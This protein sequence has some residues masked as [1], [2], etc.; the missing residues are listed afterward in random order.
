MS[1]HFAFLICF[2]SN[3]SCYSD[4][5]YFQYFS[6]N[7][8]TSGALVLNGPF[9]SHVFRFHLLATAV[10]YLKYDDE[11]HSTCCL[12]TQNCNLYRERRPVRSCEGYMRPVRCKCKLL[13]HI[14]CNRSIHH[15]R[16]A[17]MEGMLHHWMC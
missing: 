13:F 8:L 11:F 12:R 9:S 3:Y 14:K 16:Q 10:N 1:Q 15:L 7:P 17:L 5:F 2:S 4:V 6:L